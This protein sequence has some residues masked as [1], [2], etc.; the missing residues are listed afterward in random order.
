MYGMKYDRIEVR[1]D[2]EH[3]K[4]L[5]ELK[6]AYGTSASEA[7]R[8]AIDEAWWEQGR[9]RRLEAVRRMAE[10]NIEDMPDPDEL[11]RQNEEIYTRAIEE[12]LRRCEAPVDS[13]DTD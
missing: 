1:L 11:K 3:V 13:S 5:A 2:E 4:K 7:V 12:S 10:A 8:R 9:N 6:A